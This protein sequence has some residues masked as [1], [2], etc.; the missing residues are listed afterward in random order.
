MLSDQIKGNINVLLVPETKTDD[1][2]S[3]GNFL[4]DRFRLDTV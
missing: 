2:F 1:S 3:I 4:I